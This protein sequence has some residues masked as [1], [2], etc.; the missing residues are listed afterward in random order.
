MI[1][2]C[3]VATIEKNTIGARQC[4]H[5]FVTGLKKK[6]C[7]EIIV[8]KCAVTVSPSHHAKTPCAYV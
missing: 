8:Y 6:L 7:V 1:P 5:P 2:E 4:R 3:T